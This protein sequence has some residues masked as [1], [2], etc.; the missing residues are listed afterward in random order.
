MQPVSLITTQIHIQRF[1][2]TNNDMYVT[3]AGLGDVSIIDS[4]KNMLIGTISGMCP[5]SPGS[6][7][8]EWMPV[9]TLAN[10]ELGC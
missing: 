2:P 4:S 6:G 9:D 3:D 7:I 1:N 8:V 10:I 5:N